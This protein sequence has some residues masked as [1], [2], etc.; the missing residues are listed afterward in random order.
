MGH[1]HLGVLPKTVPWNQVVRLLGDGASTVVVAAASARAAERE[2]LGAGND[3]VFVEAVR[4]LLLVPQAARGDDF[5][6]ALRR[7]DLGVGAR[8]GLLDVLAGIEARLDDVARTARQR[9]DLGEFAGRALVQA[10]AEQIGDGLPGLFDPRP[11]DVA[12][13]ARLLA[14]RRGLADLARSFFA[15]LV[16]DS[17]SSWLDRTLSAQVGPDRRFSGAAERA[18]FDRALAAH[19]HGAT[20]IV[21]E[22]IPGW[23]GKR[24][25]E[26]GTISAAAARDVGA[27]SL[28]KIVEELR[29]GYGADA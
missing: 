28:K 21:Q 20:R 24:L 5:G 22:F 11:D 23:T 25:A 6:D 13:A 8:P 27:V 10:L 7:L 16:T 1:V 15:R 12:A 2:L 29:T 4:L 18:A 9:T 17:L 26:A 19:V 3:P 14:G